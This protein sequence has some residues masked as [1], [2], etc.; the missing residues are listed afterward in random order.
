MP[1]A[2]Y[3]STRCLEPSFALEVHAWLDHIQKHAWLDP[4]AP[5]SPSMLGQANASS[6]IDMWFGPASSQP[7]HAAGFSSIQPQHESTTPLA[8]AV[9]TSWSSQASA[10]L[11]FGST[12]SSSYT[13]YVPASWSSSTGAQSSLGAASL[14]SQTQYVQS[15]LVP[16]L[17][18]AG[19]L[20]GEPLQH[21]TEEG[22]HVS[23]ASLADIVADLG[24]SQRR[25]RGPNTNGSVKAA[26]RRRRLREERAAAAAAADI[27]AAGDAAV[28]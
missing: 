16:P 28:P 8:P 21:D 10:Q 1:G 6:S 9:P 23:E 14:R 24:P 18:A 13:P 2:R 17:E 5:S 19:P 26:R 20:V 27:A 4:W 3:L 12:S 25:N 22:H 11:L 15:V 7:L